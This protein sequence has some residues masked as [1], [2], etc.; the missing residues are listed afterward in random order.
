MSRSTESRG[1]GKRLRVAI[2][3]IAVAAG[4]L[5]AATAGASLDDQAR[6]PNKD[7]SV[8]GAKAEYCTIDGALKA[9]FVLGGDSDCEWRID[10]EFG[11]GTTH[12]GRL[13]NG[14]DY[15]GYPFAHEYPRPGTYEFTV[16]LSEGHSPSGIP[17]GNYRETCPVQFPK[18][19]KKKDVKEFEGLAYEDAINPR[20]K[21]FVMSHRSA[22]RGSAVGPGTVQIAVSRDTSWRGKVKNLNDLKRYP[23][24]VKARF[25][26]KRWVAERIEDEPL[27]SSDHFCETGT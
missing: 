15:P 20:K 14:G 7:G 23:L 6:E 18:T 9:S 21:T 22:G 12:T 19:P 27:H 24:E 5:I 1:Y 16:R 10:L 3:T 25:D 26:G 17:C 8:C 4:A 2:F 13:T 11:D